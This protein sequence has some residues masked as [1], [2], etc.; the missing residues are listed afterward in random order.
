MRDERET[1]AE[2]GGSGP[3]RPA[4]RRLVRPLRSAVALA[5]RLLG[6]AQ[7]PGDQQDI[8]SGEVCR[9]GRRPG[10]AAAAH[11]RHPGRRRIRHPSCG[12]YSNP[13]IRLTQRTLLWTSTAAGVTARVDETLSGRMYS[14]SVISC[15]CLTMQAPVWTPLAQA[16]SRR[17]ERC[18]GIAPVRPG[19]WAFSCL[20]GMAHPSEAGAGFRLRT[21]L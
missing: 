2:N 8:P 10:Q 3:P 11:L 16:R 15:A 9:G 14:G 5:A 7:S 12:R 1:P 17:G 18:E 20:S 21:M 13:H 6:R 4:L 19:A